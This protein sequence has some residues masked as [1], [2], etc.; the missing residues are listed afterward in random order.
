MIGWYE[1]GGFVDLTGKGK[2]LEDADKRVYR[3]SQKFIEK[4]II[5]P[6]TK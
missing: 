6:F 2:K 1:V 5:K 4:K 3:I